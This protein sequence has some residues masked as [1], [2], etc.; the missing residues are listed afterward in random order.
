MA[1]GDRG[2]SSEFLEGFRSRFATQ[3]TVEAESCKQQ[4]TSGRKRHRRQVDDLKLSDTQL[5][6]DQGRACDRPAE[7]NNTIFVML[8]IAGC[9]ECDDV[10][11]VRVV[12]KRG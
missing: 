3:T 6:A 5:L 1:R 4:K 10:L 11:S 9:R 12:P 7:T 2:P 8:L